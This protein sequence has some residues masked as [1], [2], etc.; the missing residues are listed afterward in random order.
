MKEEKGGREGKVKEGKKRRRREK[1]E[2]E[3]GTEGIKNKMKEERGGNERK[4][5]R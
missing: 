1:E 2:E 3:K 5:G 4:E